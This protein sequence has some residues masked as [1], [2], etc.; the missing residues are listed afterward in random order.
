MK[1]QFHPGTDMSQAMSETV[2]YVNRARAMMP[3]IDLCNHAGDEAT[4]PPSP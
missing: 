4:P 1:L 2:G 3:L